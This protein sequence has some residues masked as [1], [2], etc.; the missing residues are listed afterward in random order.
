MKANV[1][2]TFRTAENFDLAPDGMRVVLVHDGEIDLYRLPELSKADREDLDDVRQM[3]PAVAEARGAINLRKLA[4]DDTQS[5]PLKDAEGTVAPVSGAQPG[6]EASVAD[7][8][9]ATV[10]EGDVAPRK[11]PSLLNPGEQPEFKSKPDK[12]TPQ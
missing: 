8:A 7:A 9:R 12:S 2:P 5:A 6:K 4:E 10:A 1:T 3:R 11:P